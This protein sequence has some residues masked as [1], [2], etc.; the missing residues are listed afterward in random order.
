[1]KKFA[2]AGAIAALTMAVAGTASAAVITSF[3]PD[4]A[5]P[6]AGYTVIDKFDN[7]TGL[8]NSTGAGYLLTTNHDSQGAPPANSNP[9]GTSYLSVLGQGGVSI[10][11]SALT[12]AA[13]HAFEFDWGSIDSFNN[14]VI[15]GSSGDIT[16]VPGSLSFPNLA[17]GDQVAPGTNGLFEVV[18]NAGETFTGLTLTSGQNSFEIDNLAIP[19]V[20]EPATW[21]MMIVG[22]G[23]MGV[24]LRSRRTAAAALA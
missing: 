24:A 22:L 15:H 1:M 3:T 23:A 21:A 17:N 2:F 11:F 19:G 8:F 14:L 9:V 7:A 18:G 10:N 4:G 5:S 12:S 20:P 6:S 13:I 16:I